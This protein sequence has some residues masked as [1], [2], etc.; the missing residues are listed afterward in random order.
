[1]LDYI[2]LKNLRQSLVLTDLRTFCSHLLVRDIATS[3]TGEGMNT[4]TMRI[5]ILIRNRA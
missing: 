2:N 4:R 3:R 5:R 1:M